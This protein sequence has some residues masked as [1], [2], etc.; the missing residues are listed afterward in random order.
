MS[1]MTHDAGRVA[2]PSRL[3]AGLVLAVLSAASFGLS[4]S[5][6]AS[7]L[8]VGW[9][10]AAVVVAR[11]L[12]AVAVLVVPALVAL[13]GRWHLLRRNL[14]FVAA[15]GVAA[16]ATAQ[17]C[18]FYAVSYIPV[19]VAL[20][21]EYTAPVGV[22]LW[23][24]LRHGHRPRR[25]TVVGAVV[26]AA[27]LVLL[28]DPTGGSINLPGV[29]WGLG[30]MVGAA[31]YFVLSADEREGL[32][33]LVLAAGGLLV[34][35]VVVGVAGLLGL[36]A[37]G[38]STTDVLL[39]GTE[40]PW[41]VPIVGLAVVT[42]ALAYVLGIEAGRRLGARL[43]SF[44]ALLEVFMAVLFAWLLLSQLPRTVQLA[45][46]VLILAGVVL[47]KRDEPAQVDTSLVPRTVDEDEVR[48]AGPGVD[49]G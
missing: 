37:M 46:G 7:L 16:V 34:G 2:A 33:P 24:W 4:G 28:L 44:V 12:G 32:P 26:A 47:V 6:A 5:F 10:P 23:L 13:H 17:L 8:A 48:G 29:L 36:V 27:G 41:W 25:G 22:V 21:I 14:G 19:G 49:R 35:G 15:Y 31:A 42:A 1:T 11:I 20:L 18:F 3:G 45:G 39:A 40:V 38:S 30:A 43:A 9:S